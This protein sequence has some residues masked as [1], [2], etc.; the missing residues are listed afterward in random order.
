MNDEKQRIKNRENENEIFK[1][2]SF[3]GYEIKART[4]SV[5]KSPGTPLRTWHETVM[6]LVGPPSFSAL[7][8]DGVFPGGS[9]VAT[10]FCG[11]SARR[12]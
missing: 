8:A 1:S 11:L 6:G 4:L 9:S 12:Y 3:S 7:H 10:Y 2:E 5:R